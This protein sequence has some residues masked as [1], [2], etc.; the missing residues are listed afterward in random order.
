[1][2]QTNRDDLSCGSEDSL[3][4]TDELESQATSN[5]IQIY[6]HS[7]LHRL[8]DR[9]TSDLERL[10]SNFQYFSSYYT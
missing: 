10:K 1:M 2:K 9:I 6:S 7:K 5:K 8:V 4:G 3:S